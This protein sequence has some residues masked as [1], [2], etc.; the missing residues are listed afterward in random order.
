MW[1][2]KTAVVILGLGLGVKAA[3]AAG[4]A[5]NILFRGFAAIIEAYLIYWAL[6]YF[7]A[8]KFFKFSRE[9]AASA[10]VRHLDLRRVGG[11][12]HRG[13]DSSPA[14]SCRSWC[15]RSSSSSRSWSSSSL[16]LAARRSS[17]SNR[18]SPL[19]GCGWR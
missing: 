13:R 9:W 5:S 14:W 7:I 18:S 15:R 1:F 12:R 10:R 6:V 11:D 17:I 2:I 19:R 3:G 8:R 16:P 4:L